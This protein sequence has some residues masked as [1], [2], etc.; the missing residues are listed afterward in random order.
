MK[1]LLTRLAALLILAAV[2]THAPLDVRAGCLYGLAVG[3]VAG[4]ARGVRA[5]SWHGLKVS[6]RRLATGVR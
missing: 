5:V 4:S 2:L 6:G 1:P 3:F